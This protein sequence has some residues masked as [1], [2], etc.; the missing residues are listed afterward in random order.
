MHPLLYRPELQA[1]IDFYNTWEMRKLLFAALRM[2]MTY[3]FFHIYAL[4]SFPWPHS[5]MFPAD[6][7]HMKEI[8]TA[9]ATQ[10]PV[11][12]QIAQPAL[13]L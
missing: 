13:R 11:G 1:G 6:C 5:S 4:E 8:I 3:C 12:D 2:S 10:I 7:I 9:D